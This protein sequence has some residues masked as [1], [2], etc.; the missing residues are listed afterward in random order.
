MSVTSTVMLPFY[1]TG[2]ETQAELIEMYKIAI[3]E[4]MNTPR[5]QG[6]VLD[7]AKTRNS[8]ILD[9]VWSSYCYHMGQTNYFW[10]H[11]PPPPTEA[12]DWLREHLN[13]KI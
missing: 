3:E 13:T 9:F 5:P 4:Y 8:S 12:P 10:R 7:V 1:K 2:K 6:S 11:G